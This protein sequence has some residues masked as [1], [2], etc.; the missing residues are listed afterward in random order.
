MG[1]DAQVASALTPWQQACARLEDTFKAL[2]LRRRAANPTAREASDDA[3]WERSLTAIDQLRSEWHQTAATDPAAFWPGWERLVRCYALLAGRIP[4]ATRWRPLL[5]IAFERLA[6]LYH[7]AF[8]WCWQEAQA[9]P[10]ALWH[11]LYH[12]WQEVTQHRVAWKRVADPLTADQKASTHELVGAIL[13]SYLVDPERTPPAT[14]ARLLPLIAEYAPYLQ[15]VPVEWL[16]E[17]AHGYG[18]SPEAWHAPRHPAGKSAPLPAWAVDLEALRLALQQGKAQEEEAAP[19]PTPSRTRHH[20]LQRTLLLS[21]INQTPA[22]RQELR[23]EAPRQSVRLVSGWE[24]VAVQFPGHSALL[25]PSQA[26]SLV[27]SHRIHLFGGHDSEL[28]ANDTLPEGTQWLVWDESPS[29]WQ[30][31]QHLPETQPLDVLPQQLVALLFLTESGRSRPPVL[32]RI[33]WRNRLGRIVRLGVQRFPYRHVRTL[34]ARPWHPPGT[35]PAPWSY[36]LLLTSEEETQ[37]LIAPCQASDRLP[38]HWEVRWESQQIIAALVDHTFERG[39][40]YCWFSFQP[41]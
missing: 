31:I 39:A 16:S 10:E 38:L 7:Q 36:V 1:S 40:D 21:L 18:F 2:P 27:Y 29:G 11:A 26:G 12:L 17:A 24:S 35:T 37:S 15:L 3:P 9:I 6:W 13:L 5:A 34:T 33:R 28:V 4:N 23:Q 25:A 20:E 14:F 19:E 22:L 8:L 41:L 32:A 30:L